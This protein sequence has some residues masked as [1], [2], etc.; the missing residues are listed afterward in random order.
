MKK[1]KVKLPT[2]ILGALDLFSADLYWGGSGLKKADV[3][4]SGSINGVLLLKSK[5]YVGVSDIGTDN[6]IY[7]LT[8]DGIRFKDKII[9]YASKLYKNNKVCP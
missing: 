2:S 8:L 1:D 3:V 6:E 9:D 7:F 4:N 5:G